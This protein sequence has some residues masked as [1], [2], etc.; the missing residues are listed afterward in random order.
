[1][2]DPSLHPR[3]PRARNAGECDVFELAARRAA[4][5]KPTVVD[6]R[7]PSELQ[8]A[9]IPDVIEIPMS[10]F[11]ARWP[12]ELGH[13]R[14]QE[15]LLFCRSGGRSARVQAFLAHCGFTKTRN[16]VG[17]ILA[18]SEAIDPSQPKY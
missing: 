18:W 4:G 1:M 15:L 5:E 17:G 11:E 6:V 7:E 3:V 10:Q 14:D 13:L 16:V 2:T 12:A 8:I 9:R